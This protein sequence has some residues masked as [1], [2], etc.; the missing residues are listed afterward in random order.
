MNAAPDPQAREHWMGLLAR[1][2][3]NLL[4]ALWRDFPESEAACDEAGLT[5]LRPPETGMVMVRGRAGAVGEPFN[6]GEMTV[7]RASLRLPCGTIGHGYVQGRDH[8]KARIAALVDALMAG[9]LAA[10]VDA[11]I[12]RPLAAEEAE[13]RATRASQTAATQVAFFTMV[14]GE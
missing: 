5:W 7:T 11:A 2:R 8:A 14:R 12:I 1:S 4:A 10:R 3:P 9:P 13:M 6:L